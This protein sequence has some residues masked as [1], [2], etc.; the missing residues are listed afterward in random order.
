M[1]IPVLAMLKDVCGGTFVE[2]GAN[3]GVN[4]HSKFLEE[5]LGWRGA[6][7]EAA[8]NNFEALVKARP[9]CDNIHA[10]VWHTSEEVTFRACTG[11]LYGHSGLVSM[12]SDTEWKALMNAHRGRFT[13]TDH[14]VA[15]RPAATLLEAYETIDWF[16]LDVEGAEMFILKA[17]SWDQS[18]VTRRWSIESNKLD[19]GELVAFMKGKGYSCVHI[20]EINTFCELESLI[21]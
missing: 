18:P 17:W 19:R 13:C 1:M 5:Q 2:L 15:A 9:E 4:S 6:C 14:T 3:N 11:K 12:R 7:I 16:F 21:A 8:P 10:V 20:D